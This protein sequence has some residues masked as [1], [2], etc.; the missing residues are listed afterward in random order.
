MPIKRIGVR[1]YIW[2]AAQNNR[3][4]PQF[5]EVGE[6]NFS[7]RKTGRRTKGSFQNPIQCWRKA[8]AG[9]G[10]GESPNPTNCACVTNPTF[11]GV[12]E[13]FKDTPCVDTCGNCLRSQKRRISRKT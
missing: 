1:K 4:N 12:Q 3:E 11:N 6:A 7:H 5:K 2:V 8:P 10:G 13:V 9:W